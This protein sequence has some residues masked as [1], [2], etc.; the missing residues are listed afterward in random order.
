MYSGSILFAFEIYRHTDLQWTAS[1]SLFLTVHCGY[2]GHRGRPIVQVVSRRL[3]TAAARVRARVRPY[4]IYGG[5]SGTGTGYV[6]VLRFPLPPRI[7]PIAPQLSSSSSIILGWYNRPNSGRST[8][9]TQ[10]NPM[11]GRK[12]RLSSGKAHKSNTPRPKVSSTPPCG[13]VVLSRRG[14]GKGP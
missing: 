7:P 2:R 10:S 5:Q 9:W 12:K 11:R 1:G 13:A 14:D 4:R 8:Q 3:P 6:R